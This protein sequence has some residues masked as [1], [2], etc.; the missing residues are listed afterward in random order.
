MTTNERAD[1]FVL[2]TICLISYPTYLV[3]RFLC[4]RVNSNEVNE[5][6]IIVIAFLLYPTTRSTIL[7]PGAD[8]SYRVGGFFMSTLV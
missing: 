7:D 2:A 5:M 8:A 3:D 4:S 6:R 1:D